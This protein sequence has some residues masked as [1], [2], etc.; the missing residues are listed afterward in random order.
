M[1]HH[2][3]SLH[4]TGWPN[5]CLYY[6]VLQ[7]R[8]AS[9]LRPVSGIIP[10]TIGDIN[11]H[12]VPLAPPKPALHLAWLLLLLDL[13]LPLPPASAP[14]LSVVSRWC[15]T[16]VFV[17]TSTLWPFLCR[18]RALDSTRQKNFINIRLKMSRKWRSKSINRVVC[19]ISSMP[20]WLVCA[21]FSWEEMVIIF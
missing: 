7:C 15:E 12:F 9:C 6:V 17:R 13:P 20:L 21:T 3:W 4:L 5:S 18:S 2:W 19:S 1:W 10:T 11:K 16:T 8:I 14:C